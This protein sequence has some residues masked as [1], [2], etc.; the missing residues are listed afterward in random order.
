METAR[1]RLQRR[2]RKKNSKSRDDEWWRSPRLLGRGVP[3]Q[4]ISR[5]SIPLIVLPLRLR[6]P[7]SHLWGKGYPSLV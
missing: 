2:R 3:Q 6:T 7:T 5:I 4:N 1:K